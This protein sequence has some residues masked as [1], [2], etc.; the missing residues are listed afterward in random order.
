MPIFRKVELTK[1]EYTGG[2]SLQLPQIMQTL[3]NMIGE[4][5]IQN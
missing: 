3:S 5:R 4:V 1:P 2:D